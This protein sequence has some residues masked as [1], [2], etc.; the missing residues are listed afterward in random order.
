MYLGDIHPFFTGGVV[1][2]SVSITGEDPVSEIKVTVKRLAKGSFPGARN[3]I[4]ASSRGHLGTDR[5]SRLGLQRLKYFQ[6]AAILA[7]LYVI[8]CAVRA[9]TQ[10]QVAGGSITGT[11]RGDSGSAMPGVRISVKDVVTGQVRTALTDTSGSYSL[12]ALPAGQYEKTTSASGFFHTGRQVA[13]A[14]HNNPTTMK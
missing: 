6:T 9:V 11:A 12:P 1:D 13:Q 5:K 4:I 2:S 14:G 8:M 3:C 10:A 7:R